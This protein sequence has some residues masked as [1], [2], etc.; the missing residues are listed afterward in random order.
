MHVQIVNFRM[1]AIDEE[2]YGKQCETK[3]STLANLPR[4]PAYPSGRFGYLAR[5]RIL[6]VLFGPPQHTILLC[7]IVA[8]LRHVHNLA[9]GSPISAGH[10]NAK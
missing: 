7:S 5:L 8:F 10:G 9:N 3:A 6:A 1:K 4:A 2:D